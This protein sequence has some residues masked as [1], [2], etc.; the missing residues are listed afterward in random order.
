MSCY[1]K[2]KS[3]ICDVIILGAYIKTRKYFVKKEEDFHH[4]KITSL[5]HIL[6]VFSEVQI[7]WKTDKFF[8]YGNH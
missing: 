7:F 8:F 6:W 1:L 5:V 2:S 4:E 3:S